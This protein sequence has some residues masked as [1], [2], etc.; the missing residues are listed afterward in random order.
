[1]IRF[2]SNTSV[3]GYKPNTS[4]YYETEGRTMEEKAN[5]LRRQRY[6]E[7]KDEINEQKRIAY[8]KRV[9]NDTETE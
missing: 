7:Q 8:A 9:G 3:Q 2:N 4:L 1:M 5:T 6:S